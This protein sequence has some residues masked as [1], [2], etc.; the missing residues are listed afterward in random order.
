MFLSKKWIWLGSVFFF[1]AWMF[2]SSCEKDQFNTNPNDEI[3]FSR[4]TLTFDT[5]FTSLGTITK[6]I[7]VINPF[8]RDIKISRIRLKSNTSVFRLN[9]NGVPGNTAENIILEAKDSIYIFVAATI[10]PTAAD[11]PFIY[12]DDI[13]FEYNGRTSEVNVMAWGQ[14]AYFHYGETISGNVTWDNN[15]PHV[16]VG[17]TNADGLFVPGVLVNCGAKLTIDKGCRIYC[18]SNAGDRKSTRLNSSH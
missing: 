10:D 17:K 9:I 4:D 6:S 3:Q 15:K 13:I 1:A 12:F 2:F 16:I 5:V 11:L 8:N 7:K 18:F 14:N